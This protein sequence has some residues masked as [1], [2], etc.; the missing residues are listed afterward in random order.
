MTVPSTT[1]YAGCWF[2]M[3]LTFLYEFCR[4][5][6][7][8]Q[9]TCTCSRIEKLSVFRGF[10]PNL[11]D[12]NRTGKHPI[13][14]QWR[15]DAEIAKII[16]GRIGRGQPDSIVVFGRVGLGLESTHGW[17]NLSLGIFL[18]AAAFYLKKIMYTVSSLVEESNDKC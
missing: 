11:Q 6:T 5:N 1:V 8:P 4:D 15:L 3:P 17:P 10:S 16:P 18:L 7:T 9:H 12:L 2:P 13:C 14:M